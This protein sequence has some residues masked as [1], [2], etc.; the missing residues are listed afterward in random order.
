M[1]MSAS[2]R[3][4]PLGPNSHGKGKPLGRRMANK[5]EAEQRCMQIIEILRERP[6]ITHRELAQMLGMPKS[7]VESYIAK[8]LNDPRTKQVVLE[9]KRAKELNKRLKREIKKRELL[10]LIRRNILSQEELIKAL[11]IGKEF[12]HSLVREI[13]TKGSDY[14]KELVARLNFARSAVGEMPLMDKRQRMLLTTYLEKFAEWKDRPTP[15]IDGEIKRLNL[16]IKRASGEERDKL[17]M[18]VNALKKILEKRRD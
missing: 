10:E 17:Q 11:G 6:T 2:M 8:L 14:E 16:E 18:M 13:M 1:I 3:R 7:T 15:A 12:L 4:M 5:A 9:S